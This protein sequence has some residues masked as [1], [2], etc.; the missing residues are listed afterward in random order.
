M[1]IRD[2]PNS[3]VDLV[4]PETLPFGRVKT[5]GRSSF[6]DPPSAKADPSELFYSPSPS[7]NSVVQFLY[8]LPPS[9]LIPR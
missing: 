1:K 7:P 8:A 2:E 6:G 5:I 9:R 3:I 4:R